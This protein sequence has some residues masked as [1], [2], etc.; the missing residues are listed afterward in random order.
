MARALREAR[1]EEA[2]LSEMAGHADTDD[3]LA[4]ATSLIEEMRYGAAM[5]LLERLAESGE[6]RIYSLMG[7]MH[8]WGCQ[9]LRH[10]APRAATCYRKGI[11]EGD[12]PHAHI[13]LGRILLRGHEGQERDLAAAEHHLRKAAAAGEPSSD[14]WLGELLVERHKEDG[15]FHEAEQRL[16]AAAAAGYVC[17][18]IHLGDIDRFRGNNFA[19]A[20]KKLRSIWR[21][22]KLLRTDPHSPLLEGMQFPEN[23]NRSPRVIPFPK[24]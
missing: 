10:D 9:D 15:D 13:G 21:M 6:W 22:V 14:M 1:R 20:G 23:P 5:P 16:K 3:P 11:F 7:D 17:A 18:L 19:A 12:D 4:A 24:R 2:P 8:Y